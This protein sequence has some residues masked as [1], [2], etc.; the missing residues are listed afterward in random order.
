MGPRNSALSLERYP[1]GSEAVAD[2][3]GAEVLLDCL[4]VG[5]SFGRQEA[6]ELGHWAAVSKEPGRE[7]QV[8]A[9]SWAS[10]RV[11][12]RVPSIHRREGCPTTQSLPTPSSWAPALSEADTLSLGPCGRSLG[13]PQKGRLETR[14]CGWRVPWAR[15]PHLPRRLQSVK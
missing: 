14:G 7:G 8:G 13:F 11:G 9:R 10:R 5:K 12:M 4:L 2:L 15:G 3:R 6:G 1:R